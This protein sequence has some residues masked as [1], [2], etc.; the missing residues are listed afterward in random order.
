MRHGE[1]PFP[2]AALLSIAALLVLP[3]CGGPV[4]EEATEAVEQAEQLAEDLVRAQEEAV[5]V[6]R[7][8]IAGDE[9]SLVGGTV[10]F[11]E[12]LGQVTV[13]AELEGVTPP[14]P[15][16]LH[17][18]EVGDCTPPDFASAGG[19]FNPTGADHACPPT[20]SRHAGDLG[21]V[22][23]GD[24]GTGTLELV[25]NLLTVTAGPMSVAGRAVVLHSREDDCVTQPSGDSGERIGC[26]TIVLV[27]DEEGGSGTPEGRAYTPAGTS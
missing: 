20:E 10:T 27:G 21:N 15:H 23:I 22:M 26:G 8:V 19:H 24:D 11:T 25:T 14:G 13:R 3:A 17:V 12:S 9:T 1:H 2:V 7:A 5:Y 16:G 18:H 6:A 4:E